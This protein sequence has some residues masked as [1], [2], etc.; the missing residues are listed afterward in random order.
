LTLVTVGAFARA[1]DAVSNHHR[2]TVMSFN[3]RYGTAQDGVN[4]WD[5][6]HNC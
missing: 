3:I 5:K 1:D 4:H 6:R 2:L